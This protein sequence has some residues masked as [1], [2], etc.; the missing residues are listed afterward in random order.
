MDEAV[1]VAWGLANVVGQVETCRSNGGIETPLDRYSD[2]LTHR[3]PVQICSFGL[4]YLIYV[5]E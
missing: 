5:W 3:H 1:G 4:D 2:L